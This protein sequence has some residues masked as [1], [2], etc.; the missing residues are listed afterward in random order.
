VLATVCDRMGLDPQSPLTTRNGQQFPMLGEG[1]PI[2][3]LM[4]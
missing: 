1:K 4:A 3:A 2:E